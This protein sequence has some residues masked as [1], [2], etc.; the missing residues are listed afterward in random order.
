MAGDSQA[1][2]VAAIHAVCED[3]LTTD[4]AEFFESGFSIMT[5]RAMLRTHPGGQVLE[6]DIDILA[7]QLSPLVFT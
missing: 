1:G 2:F 6:E 3:G 4:S 5:V 7:H